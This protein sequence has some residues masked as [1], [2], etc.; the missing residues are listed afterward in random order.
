MKHNGA[1]LLL[2]MILFSLLLGA[3]WLEAVRGYAEKKKAKLIE[4]FRALFPDRCPI[5]S[6]H[7]YQITN[8]LE[9]AELDEHYCIERGRRV[10][11][12][13]DPPS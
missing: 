7:Y 9:D 11:A 3:I 6:F 12:K 2:W 8:G 4:Q 10:G 13:Y 1:T 5:C